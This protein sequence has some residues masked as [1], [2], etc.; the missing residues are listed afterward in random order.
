MR[1]L[2]PLIDFLHGQ[3]ITVLT[4]AGI[5][6]DSGIPD[7]RGPKTRHKARNPIQYQ[8]FIGS[9]AMR[10]R[11]WARSLR[12]WLP[13]KRAEPNRS[14][15]ILAE[16]EERGR[17]VGVI[18]QNVDGLHQA[19]GSHSVV[20]LHGTLSRVRCLACGSRVGRDWMQAALLSA[21]PTER[22]EA[23]QELAPDGD[24]VVD[25]RADFRVPPCPSC[26]GVLKPDVVFF[27]ENTERPV[28]D[29]AWSLFEQ[30]EVLLVLGSSLTVFSGYRFVHRARKVGMPVAIVS[31]G[32]TRGDPVAAMKVDAP[33]LPVLEVLGRRL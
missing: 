12:G 29:A 31:L 13:V 23:P 2:E 20:E 10:R 5:S 27:G 1:S 28:V 11:Y 8:Q 17:V 9:D 26:G 16:L 25:V 30:G 21:N 24:A 33:L 14:H 7:Y 19:A 22:I 3:R 18:T 4:G 32:P 6:T 15:E